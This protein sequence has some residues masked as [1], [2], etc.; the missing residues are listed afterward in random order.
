MDALPGGVL[1][2]ALL[3]IVKLSNTSCCVIIFC[4]VDLEL[5]GLDAVAMIVKVFPVV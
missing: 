1:T 4:C 2:G 5:T 3:V